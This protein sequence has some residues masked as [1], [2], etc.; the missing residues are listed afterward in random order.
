MRNC[1]LA[2][3]CVKCGQK[4]FSADCGLPRKADLVRVDSNATREAVK[5]ANCSGQHTANYRGCPTRKNYVAKLAEKKAKLRSLQ[6]TPPILRP[7]R[8]TVEQNGGPSTSTNPSSRSYAQALS[9]ESNTVNSIT[10]SEFLTMAR[11]V[12][13][14]LGKCR[15]R[16]D[17]LEALVE[18]TAKF[19]FNV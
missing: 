12:F 15:S 3:L 10:M 4:H 5:C 8:N 7:S 2:P 9:Q 14:E 13:T 1:N 16:Q 6:Q 11:A 19:I 17:Y 18:L